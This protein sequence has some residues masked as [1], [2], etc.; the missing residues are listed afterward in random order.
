MR[1]EQNAKID[2]FL[3]TLQLHYGA[4]FVPFSLSRNAK[5]NPGLHELSLNWVVGIG[6]LSPIDG[7]VQPGAL[8][9]DYQQ[10]IAY[11]P[12][13]QPSM[14]PSIHDVVIVRRACE[15]GRYGGII[16]NK[17]IPAPALRDVM[18][19]LVLDADVI[20]Y[21]NFEEWADGLGFNP[22][23]RKDEK[24]YH[25]C[26]EVALKLRLLIGEEAIKKLHEGQSS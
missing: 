21:A 25:A 8:A 20:E 16:A 10:G 13:Y 12:G 11:I 15:T 14:R 2:E 9:T 19:S 18:Y 3:D 17:P 23:S 26:M 4:T 1:A 22:D 6:K 24:I 7:Q 5:S